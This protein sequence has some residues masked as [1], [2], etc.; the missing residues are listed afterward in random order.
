MRKKDE[1]FY[2]ISPIYSV[3]QENYRDAIK[4]F[5]FYIKRLFFLHYV[6]SKIGTKQHHIQRF[7]I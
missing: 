3:L 5:L 4:K 2:Q 6:L 1:T 7:F